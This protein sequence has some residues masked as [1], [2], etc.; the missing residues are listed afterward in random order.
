MNFHQT[1]LN[2]SYFLRSLLIWIDTRFKFHKTHQIDI[3]HKSLSFSLFLPFFRP[4]PH[5]INYSSV[6]TEQNSIQISRILCYI[7]PFR[8]SY[9]RFWS[10]CFRG[11]SIAKHG[12]SHNTVVDPHLTS[13]N[14]CMDVFRWDFQ[15]SLLYDTFVHL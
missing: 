5:S 6:I 8:T 13:I 2:L 11:S 1:R 10:E 14:Y 7:K 4:S 9:F 3:F 12:L 15:D